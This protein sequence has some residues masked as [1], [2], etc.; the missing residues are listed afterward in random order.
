MKDAGRTE[1]ANVAHSW[2][3]RKTRNVVLNRMDFRYISSA[4]HY[5]ACD[6]RVDLLRFR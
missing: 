3:H 4:L 5:G 1:D 6:L 2:T